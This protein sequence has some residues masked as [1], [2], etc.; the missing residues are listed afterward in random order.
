MNYKYIAVIAIFL[1]SL[2]IASCGASTEIV[3]DWSD[4]NY[5]KGN[6]D[7][8]LVL[9]IVNKDKPLLR[10]RV[11]DG[12]KNAFEKH[13][14]EAIPSMDIMPYDETIDSTTFDKYFKDLNFDAVITVRVVGLEKDRN[15][16]AGYA[17]VVPY[18]NYYGFYGYYY[19]A[20]SYANTSGY[21]SKSV[22]VVIE[23]NLYDAKNKKLIWSGIS[24]TIDPDKA[25]DVINSVGSALVDKLSSEGFIK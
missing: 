19:A 21:L 6:I 3:G 15:Y 4:S 9:G 17:Y 13:G 2:V 5:K 20:V 24:E 23:N 11:E 22:T 10:R 25:S 7:K 14:I 8:L 12:L 1:L 18:N 16:K